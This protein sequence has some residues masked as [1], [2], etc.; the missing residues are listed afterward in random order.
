[1]A[2]RN[3]KHS[4]MARHI[5]AAIWLADTCRFG[6]IRSNPLKLFQASLKS[7]VMIVFRHQYKR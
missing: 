3:S 6:N 1:L 7:I 2:E 5:S 4:L